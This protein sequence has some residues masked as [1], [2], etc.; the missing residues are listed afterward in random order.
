MYAIRSYYASAISQAIQIP[1]IAGMENNMVIF[2][3]DKEKPDNLKK[4]VENFA[5]VNSGR[6]DSYNFV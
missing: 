4:V 5:L 6:F 1:G 2:E 3:Y